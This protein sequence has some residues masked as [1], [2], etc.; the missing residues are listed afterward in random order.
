M[1]GRCHGSGGKSMMQELRLFLTWLVLQD[2][3]RQSR[4]HQGRQRK[5]GEIEEKP[6]KAS[7]AAEGRNGRVFIVGQDR[8]F[9]MA[10]RSSSMLKGFPMTAST[11]LSEAA[12]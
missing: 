10:R 1:A 6:A 2:K 12:S 11:G 4:V 5:G 8:S 3:L 7:H 9:A